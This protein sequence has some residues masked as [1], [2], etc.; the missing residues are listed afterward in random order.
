[1]YS[2]HNGSARG[3]HGREI[4]RSSCN[5]RNGSVIEKSPK[6]KNYNTQRNKL[7]MSLE[8]VC[9]TVESLS[10]MT[11]LQREQILPRSNDR[12]QRR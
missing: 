1:M 2:T 5:C 11:G 6:R 7:L 9:D 3:Y 10:S 4:F 12:C 8:I